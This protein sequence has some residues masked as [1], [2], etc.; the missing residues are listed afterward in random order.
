MASTNLIDDRIKPTQAILTLA[1]PV[2]IEQVLSTLVQSVD[3]A[4]V[5]SLGASAT[6]SVSISA[7]PM[8]LIMGIV[9]SFGMGFTALIARTV[10]AQDFERANSLTRQALTT[11]ILLGLPIVF[12]CYSLSE[13]VPRLMGAEPDVLVLATIY[14]KTIAYGMIFRVLT[15][16]LS[17][18]YRGFGDSKTP[19]II[20]TGVNLANVVGNYLLIYQPHDV[21]LFGNTFHVWGAGWGVKGAAASTS[22]MSAIGATIYLVLTFVRPSKMKISIKDSFKLQK[23]DMQAVVKISLPAMFERFTMGGASVVIASTVASL[24]TIAIA[25][26]SLA[27]TV[28]SFC[29]MPGFAFGAAST[30]LVGQSLGAKR[31]DKADEYVR[32]SIKMAAA[33]MA[34]LSTL[35]FI[36][37][38]QLITLF[39]KDAQVIFTGS[40]L[41][42]LLALIQVP[43]MISMIHSGALRGA[44]D[45]KGPFYITL[46]SMWGVRVLSA[47]VCVRILHMGIHAVILC[48]DTDNIVR[49]LLFWRRFKQGK[50]KETHFL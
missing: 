25:S 28:E 15:M 33:L 1:W 34:V 24:G 42:K 18:I 38:G 13:T 2:F 3:T 47:T 45:T 11:V 8:M 36:F 12:T 48:M 32:I 37:S 29:Y 43:Y 19:M 16:V 44:G 35:M 6:A 23:R 20:N 30:T 5:G 17:S 26:N 40:Q 31:P 22:L 10:G 46:F 39:T 50:W 27:A 21:T 14:N 7:T 4:M 49:M 9:M 41:I